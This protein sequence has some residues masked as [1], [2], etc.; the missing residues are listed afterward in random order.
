MNEKPDQAFLHGDCPQTELESSYTR[1]FLKTI[2]TSNGSPYDQ[3]LTTTTEPVIAEKRKCKGC[4]GCFIIGKTQWFKKPNRELIRVFW[5][6]EFK[7]LRDLA[8]HEAELPITNLDTYYVGHWRIVY[9]LQRVALR[10]LFE[11][12]KRARHALDPDTLS[13]VLQECYLSPKEGWTIVKA[14]DESERNYATQEERVLSAVNNLKRDSEL[15]QF[16]FEI[17]GQSKFS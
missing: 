12:I 10:Y 17:I 3:G 4:P 2:I 11:E 15:C 8:R 16:L 13:V 5:S 14:E 1:Q 9:H 7:R 6:P